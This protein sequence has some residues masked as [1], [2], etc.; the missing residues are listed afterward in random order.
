MKQVEIMTDSMK[1]F[2]V[3][4]LRPTLVL[5]SIA[6]GS[7]VL[8]DEAPLPGSCAMTPA[9]ILAEKALATKFFEPGITPQERVALFDPG[10]IQHNPLFVKLAQEKHISAYD[11]FKRVFSNLGPPPKAAKAAKAPAAKAS[12]PA[13]PHNPLVIVTAECDIV[14]VI[15]KILRQ[16]PTEAS[17][18]PQETFT[19]D[20]FRVRNGKVLEHW[21]GEIISEQ[22]MQELRKLDSPPK[23]SPGA[24]GVR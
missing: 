9:Q 18:V 13:P 23:A 6:W 15:R 5:L 1:K 12:S 24:A 17:G 8:A 4:S 14:T 10:Y 7:I 21:D 19:W 2:T 22:N 11:E 3:R 16:D 20:T